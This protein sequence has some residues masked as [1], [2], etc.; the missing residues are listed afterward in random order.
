[1]LRIKRIYTFVLQTF[2]PMFLMTFAI[3][4]FILLMQ[5]LWRYIEDLVGKGLDN[6]VLGEL[7]FYAALNLIPMGL[8]LAILLASLM[9]FGNMGERLELLAIKASGVSLLKAMQPLII[10]ISLVCIGAFFFQ[11]EAMP[12]INVKFRSIL[13]SVKQKSPE[14]EI[15]EGSFY[16]GIN[17]YSIYVK[18][19][20]PLTRM[21]HGVKIYDTSNGFDNMSV[22]VCD[23]AI[24]RVSS[25]KDFLLLSLHTGQ[26]FANFKD[27][28]VNRGGSA[29][30]NQFV[31]YS[32]ENFKTKNII[33]PFD[34]NFN[35]IDES[36]YEGTQLAKNIVKLQTSIDSMKKDI[37]SINIVDR[38]VIKRTYLSYRNEESYKQH[39]G[40]RDSTAKRNTVEK[41]LP[42]LQ[43]DSVMASYKDNQ[44]IQI[45]E[46]AAASSESGR[47]NYMD[48]TM[49]K[50][51]TQK[52]IRYHKIEWHQKFTL[53]F[54][55]LIFFFIG[56][57][58]GAIIRKGGLGMPVVVSVLF[59]IFYY[60]I[61]NIGLKFARDGVWEVWQGMW[62]SSMVLF[63]IGVFLTYKAMNDSALFNAE[64]YGK[65]LRKILRIRIPEKLNNEERNTIIQKIP[66]LKDIQIEEELLL[67]LQKLDDEKLRDI[68]D[69]Y[70]SYGYDRSTQTAALSILK[71]KNAEFATILDKQDVRYNKLTLN[72]F[73]S[74][75]MWTIGGYVLCSALLIVNV[76]IVTNLII[77]SYL[78]L[79][80]RSLIYY[81]AFYENLK[82]KK[83]TYHI[84]AWI[85]A[86]ACYPLAYLYIKRR[87]IKD[88]E[89]IET[90]TFSTNNE[91]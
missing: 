74:S 3:C 16:S 47:F 57:P 67:N 13:A 81:I 54:A 14:L 79:Y 32:R 7:F 19:K 21:L 9:T 46:S 48:R 33:I 90:F 52:K 86:L 17:N 84:I 76:P 29:Y 11:N 80:L 51:D 40:Q 83:N 8:P 55:C 64:A 71:K 4:L 43:F 12:R 35:R 78:V 85:S 23:S 30:N 18:K 34:A 88:I 65:Y 41:Q 70:K 75:S 42:S 24:M 38:Q 27:G 31:P 68:V 2:F 1:M 58:L 6:M 91:Q 45:Y 62:L 20:D 37:D 73:C 36:S 49:S 61:N 60:I 63:P 22:F 89:T 77:V 44:L 66:D 82:K 50:V 5:F 59:F 39:I 56:A 15:P 69:N 28:G 25:N 53:S 72:N 10:F 26:R 87:M